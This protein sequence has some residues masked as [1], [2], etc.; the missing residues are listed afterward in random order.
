MKM[1]NYQKAAQRTSRGDHDRL[2]AG[3]LGLIGESGEVVDILKKQLYQGLAQSKARELLIDELGDVLWY[4][5]EACAGIGR[6]IAELEAL[7]VAGTR[8]RSLENRAVHLAARACELHT[9][10]SRV[11]VDM[12]APQVAWPRLAAIYRTVLSIC[13]ALGVAIGYVAGKNIRKL[14]GRYPEGFSEEISSAR[15]EDEED[16]DE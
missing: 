7:P 4:I 9:A 13:E 3:V 2:H 12:Y 14:R 6:D 10:L 11:E 5:A 1:Q 15:Y 16:E 8:P